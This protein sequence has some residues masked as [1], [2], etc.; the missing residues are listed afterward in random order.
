MLCHQSTVPLLNNHT[1]V[2]CHAVKKCCTI[3]KYYAISN[4][5]TI[6]KC[7]AIIKHCAVE[8]RYSVVKY[9]AI[10]KCQCITKHWTIVKHC[11]A[12]LH[13]YTFMPLNLCVFELLH[14]FTLEPNQLI[15]NYLHINTTLNCIFTSYIYIYPF[16]LQ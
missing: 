2:K 3:K 1:M 5:H 9:H 12:P 4:C 15:T 10:V 16:I 7:H 6:I 8:K 13:L 11:V 14:L